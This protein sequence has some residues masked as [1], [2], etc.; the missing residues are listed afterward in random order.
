MESFEEKAKMHEQ[1]IAN[2]S[3]NHILWNRHGKFHEPKNMGKITNRNWK[4]GL[5]SKNIWNQLNVNISTV[6]LGKTYVYEVEFCN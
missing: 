6:G 5:F 1:F 2:K 4:F 3:N